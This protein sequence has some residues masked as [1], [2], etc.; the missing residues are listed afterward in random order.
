MRKA[1]L[2][3]ILCLAVVCALLL[4]LVMACGETPPPTD[5]SNNGTGTSNGG[6]ATGEKVVVQFR[7]NGAGA[8]IDGN[9]SV[10]VDKGGKLDITAVPDAY[11]DGYTFVCWA[12][13]KLGDN[14]W[15]NN[16]VFLETT[17]LYAIWSQGGNG[18]NNGGSDN[19]GTDNSGTNNSGTDNSGTDQG[20]TTTPPA[21]DTTVLIE[22]NTGRGYFEDDSLYEI[23]IKVGGRLSNLPTPIH[24]DPAMLFEGWYRDDKFTIAVSK[25]DKY[26]ADTMLYAYW[27][28]QA[29]CTDGT[30]NH[31]YTTWDQDTQPSCTK[32]GTVARYCQYCNDKQTKQ[33]DP[34]KGHLFGSW[35][36][37]FMARQ[38]TC[39]RLGCGEIEM[40][41]F[42][43]VTTAVLGNNPGSQI[44]GNDAQ[45][46]K[47]PFTALVNG[48][49]DEGHGHFV[50]PN[51]TGA[52]Y[53][54]F[55]LAEPT[56]LDRI[57]FKGDGSVAMT[58]YVQY[59]GE[60]DYTFIG[61]CGGTPD[62]ESTPFKEPD[63]N[64]KIV[65]VKFLEETPA[66]GTSMW[67][68]VAFVKVDTGE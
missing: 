64:K 49:W 5:S 31:L 8:T 32:A 57:Y 24:E 45:F 43:D 12:Y 10:E 35:Q 36:E 15:N 63:P 42:K 51:G 11:R 1:T 68:E 56:A 20:G 22:F 53:V 60:D 47:V 29:E 27:I 66:Q 59:E 38:R 6:N 61:L 41:K 52:A 44:E 62:K 33:G 23:E 13:D 19:S 9:T 50:G 58:I 7:G 65:K 26:E 21:G 39:Q 25:S 46:Y 4:P 2:V 48:T 16:D 55:T 17:I 28:Q 34:A 18:G 14:S 30:Y 67:Q 40:E 54:I 3:K 37:A